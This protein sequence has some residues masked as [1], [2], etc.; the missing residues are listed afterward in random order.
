MNRERVVTDLNPNFVVESASDVSILGVEV[1]KRSEGALEK[2]VEHS[3]R[4]PIPPMIDA[5]SVL[6]NVN[7]G[8]KP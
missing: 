4:L 3:L 8:F 6:S 2:C 5:D 7:F 1:S